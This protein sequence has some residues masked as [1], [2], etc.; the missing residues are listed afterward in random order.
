MSSIASQLSSTTFVRGLYTVLL[1]K[2]MACIVDSETKINTA[3]HVFE[4]PLASA[5]AICTN[6]PE[7]TY[8]NRV[9]TAMGKFIVVEGTDPALQ[10]ELCYWKWVLDREHATAYAGLTPQVAETMKTARTLI[11][12]AVVDT[13][14][15]PE[16]TFGIFSF[17]A[18]RN[19]HELQAIGHVELNVSTQE[20]RLWSIITRP[21][22]LKHTTLTVRGA[23]YAGMAFAAQQA[24]KAKLPL[25]FSS[26]PS[27]RSFYTEQLGL[28]PIS[29][30]PS[31]IASFRLSVEDCQTLVNRWKAYVGC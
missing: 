16:I 21:E 24:I 26:M 11:S 31:N 27:S 4:K 2:M 7:P 19:V 17:N 20:Y 15:R 22:N 6:F 13:D 25:S 14:Q 3:G 8:L 23:G 12:Q 30:S 28:E 5:D 10:S 29:I 1:L 18:E 9:G